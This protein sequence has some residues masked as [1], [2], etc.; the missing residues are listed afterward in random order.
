MRDAAES[1]LIGR[2]VVDLRLALVVVAV[3]AGTYL[4]SLPGAFIYDDR[5]IIA[6]NPLVRGRATAA[7]L[8]ASSYWQRGESR[9]RSQRPSEAQYRPLA[10]LSYNLNHRLSGMDPFWF[11]LVNVGLHSA[12]SLILFLLMA[13][14]GFSP[15]AAVLGSLAFAVLPVHAEAV[16]WTVG[17]AEVLAAVFVLGAWLLLHEESRWPRLAAGLACYL[18]ALLSKESAASFPAVLVLGEAFR[19]QGPWKELIR[20]RLL[21]WLTVFGMLA[22]YLAWRQAILGT[23]LHTGSPYFPDSSRLVILLTMAKFFFS[24]WLAPMVSGLGLCADYSRPVFPDASAG[25]PW[26][27]L[28]LAAIVGVALWTLRSFLAKRSPWAFAVLVFCCLAAPLSNILVQMGIIGAERIMYL[29]SA[30]FSL[31]LCAGWD[32]LRERGKLSG[33]WPRAA[34]AGVLLW[35]A[36]LTVDRNRIWQS[37]EAF[38]AA[39][40]ACAPGSPRMLSGLGMVRDLAGRHAEARELYRKALEIEPGLLQAAF[41]MGKSFYDEGDWRG[42]KAWF[43]R[44][45][46][47]PNVD[48]D[49]LCFLGLIA[50]AQAKPREAL[51]YYSRVLERDPTHPQAL[52]NAGLLLFKTGD[53]RAGTEQL[54]RYLETAP[55]GE[56]RREIAAFLQSVSTRKP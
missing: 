51:A 1:G 13:G 23:A 20:K 10:I 6:E 56:D 48:K 12:A 19:R 2:R 16:S 31:L 3:S 37:E 30:G 33:P 39:T 4:N 53:P 43:E 17:R 36:G 47:L 55:A 21:V 52:R 14:M 8:L 35:W 40:A 34:A 28:S 41:N 24:G 54:R 46:S 45:E 22:V 11:H 32:R 44:L 26:A 42:A 7:A 18:L 50:E 25:D 38:Y 27:W 29:P 15:G 5:P 49:T 9:Q